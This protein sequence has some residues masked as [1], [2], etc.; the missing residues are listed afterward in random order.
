MEQQVKASV[1]KA[2]KSVW[3]LTAYDGSDLVS[4]SLGP[5]Q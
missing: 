5:I 2:K 3:F 1:E 4:T